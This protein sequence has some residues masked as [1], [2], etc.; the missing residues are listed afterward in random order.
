MAFRIEYP[1]KA[2]ARIRKLDRQMLRRVMARIEKLADEPRPSGCIRLEGHS[3][4]Y[5]VRV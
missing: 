4:V 1:S 3:D 5:R 2:A